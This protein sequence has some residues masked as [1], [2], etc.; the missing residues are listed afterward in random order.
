MNNRV[1]SNYLNISSLF[2]PISRAAESKL[3]KL[4]TAAQDKSAVDDEEQTLEQPITT[5]ASGAVSDVDSE[6]STFSNPVMKTLLL[7]G[8]ACFMRG[9]AGD[10][11][12]IN[13]DRIVLPAVVMA[14]H[15]IAL[16]SQIQS[17]Q[18]MTLSQI[19]QETN[20]LTGSDGSSVFQGEALQ[21]TEGVSKRSGTDMSEDYKQAFSGTSGSTVKKW[22]D[23]SLGGSTVAAVACSGPGQLLQVVITLGGSALAAFSDV[24]SGGALT[25]AVVGLWALKEG[26][27]FAVSAVAMHFIQE[28]VL[29]K[30]TLGELGKDAFSGSEGGDLLAYGA[31][32]AGNLGAIAEGGIQLSGSAAKTLT[33]EQN[34]QSEQQFHSESLFA[35]VFN[36]DDYRSLTGQ[37]ADS[38]SPS[39]TD[40]FATAASGVGNLTG[41]LL[42][43]MFSVFMPKTSAASQPYNWGFPEDGI[44]TSI[45]D[46]ANMANPYT[47][48]KDVATVLDAQC[49]NSDGTVNTSCDY[50]SKA[51]TCFGVN[52]DKDSS[53][54][55]DVIP[56]HLVDTSS[57][58]Y[59]NA[60]CDDTSD[61]TWKRIML[62]VLDT[63][64]MQAIGCFEGD[65]QSCQETGIS[66]S[67]PSDSGGSGG[68]GGS[69]PTG[70]AKDLA[71][72][73][74]PY[75]AQGKISCN[76]Q[77]SDCPDIQ[78]TAKGIS[79][80]GGEGC[81]VDALQP[82]LLGMLLKLVQDGHTFVLSAICSDHFDDGLAGHAGGRAADFNYIDGVF[83]GE[84][85]DADGTIPW[86][87]QGSVGQKK[88]QVDQNLLQ[89]VTSFMPKSTGFGQQQCRPNFSFLSG[90]NVFPD[91]CHHQHIQVET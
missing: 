6:E 11:N 66:T 57:D 67:Q 71:N 58:D 33:Y 35:R 64:N 24:S 78:N 63:R 65:Q 14:L 40:N 36:I 53:G 25:P 62:F 7:T 87:S 31:R 70:S 68:S 43:N 27:S 72:Q 49:L 39:M 74:L 9:I 44:P 91:G 86:T 1:F 19:G 59:I 42:S 16:G 69:L 75:I 5:E 77:A 26:E 84:G 3:K 55:W 85:E 2:H 38:V 50:I 22:A 32:S 56:D 73:L 28:F 90:F 8:G 61:S 37:L 17:G 83:M 34:Q 82:G 21:A 20:S 51:N 23:D 46:D 80:K 30:S 48:S 88:I 89:D 29:N 54:A 12:T 13:R 60:H 41:S 76:S 45:L 79:I 18:D 47:N 10:I 81:Q 52:I 15:F 4:A